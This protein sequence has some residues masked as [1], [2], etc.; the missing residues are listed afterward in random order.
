MVGTEILSLL[1]VDLFIRSRAIGAKLACRTDPLPGVAIA[2]IGNKAYPQAMNKVSAFPR[3][4][5]LV[6]VGD[7]VGVI[8]PEDLL[9]RL[10]LELG[11]R[12]RVADTPVGFAVVPESSGSDAQMAVAREVMRTRR[13]ALA[14]L[15]K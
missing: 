3:S 7:A 2:T 4:L 14:E 1:R 11:D 9:E 10:G 13:K 12:V 15:A 8:L 5:E 6:P